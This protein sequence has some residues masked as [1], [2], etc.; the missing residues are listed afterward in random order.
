MVADEVLA[1]ANPF[2]HLAGWAC[3]APAIAPSVAA[4]AG[5]GIVPAVTGARA[6]E[7][8]TAPLFSSGVSAGVAVGPAR[9]VER[10]RGGE[11]ERVKEVLGYASEKATQ[12]RT[13]QSAVALFKL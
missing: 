2:L 8:P 13:T 1:H 11:M 12:T 7:P 3:S 10:A 9:A 6:R 4:V 5:H